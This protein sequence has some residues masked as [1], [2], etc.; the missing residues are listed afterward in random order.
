VTLHIDDRISAS[1][2]D[3]GFTSNDIHLLNNHS[4]DVQQNGG[5]CEDYPCCGH[6]WGDCNGLKYGSDQAIQADPHLLC[7]HEN[8][9]CQ[10]DYEDD[11]DD[12]GWWDDED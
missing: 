6:E 10:V 7:D 4:C 12:S 11:D 5:H 8:G 1:C 2:R 9:D 3:C